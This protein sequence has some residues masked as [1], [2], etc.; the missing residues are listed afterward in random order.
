[1]LKRDDS[2]VKACKKIT[3]SANSI[4]NEKQARV[5]SIHVRKTNRRAPSQLLKG[6]FAADAAFVLLE[7]FLT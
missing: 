2:K 5:W 7:V 4:R 1:M 6:T 3:F